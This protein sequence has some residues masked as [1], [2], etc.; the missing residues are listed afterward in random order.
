[1][2]LMD[3]VGFVLA[4]LQAVPLDGVE[5]TG[6]PNS[7]QPHNRDADITYGIDDVPPWYLCIFMALQ[8]R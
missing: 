4:S 5:T 2:L 6:K 3:A 8:V 1:M 7:Q